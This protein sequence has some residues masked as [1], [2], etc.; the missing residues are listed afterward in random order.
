METPVEG[1]RPGE[2]GMT[3]LVRDLRQRIDV[4][5]MEPVRATIPGDAEGLGIRMRASADA[6][7]CFEEIAGKAEFVDA[8]RGGEPGRTGTDDRDVDHA[9]HFRRSA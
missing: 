1:P 9:C 3:E 8:P 2:I 5:R 6:R 4:R 7:L